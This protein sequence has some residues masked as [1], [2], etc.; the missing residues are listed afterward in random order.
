MAGLPSKSLTQLVSDM[1]AA[2]AQQLGYQPTLPDGDPLL[3]L[4]QATAAQAVFL[5]AQIQIVNGLTLA[6]TRTGADLDEWMA[7]FDFERLGATA[8]TGQVTFGKLS[9]AASQI[10]IPPGVIVQTAG[11]AIQYMV[12]AD[13]SQP[14]WSATLNAYVL[15]VGQSSLTATVQAQ[16]AGSAY[17]VTANQISQIASNL[18]GID[19][20]TNAAAITNGLNAESDTAFL[21]RFVQ[22]LNSLSKAT[23]GAIVSAIQ[24]VQQ[25]LLY[26]LQENVDTGGNAHPGEF[27]A[28][29]D[30]GSGSPPSSLINSVQAALEAVR[31]FTILAETIAVTTVT[32]TIVVVVRLAPGT[33]SATVNAAAAQ[34]VMAAVNSQ[35]IGGEDGEGSLLYISQIESAAAATPGVVAVQPNTTTINGSAADLAGNARQRAITSLNHITVSNY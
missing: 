5:Q 3:A 24:G 2:W 21:A 19:T 23:Y 30:D 11:G 13:A 10:L 27:V 34:A 6:S 31:G 12:V 28:T 1:V 35:P 15:A 25:G 29:I 8:A 9:P 4:M 7:Q 22:Y 14:T 26:G 20:V 16:T 32:A 18:P 17:N 33:V